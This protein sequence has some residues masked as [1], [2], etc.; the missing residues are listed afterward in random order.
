MESLVDLPV[1][2]RLQDKIQAFIQFNYN[3]SLVF[4]PSAELKFQDI[5]DYL[6]QGTGKPNLALH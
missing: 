5:N 4:A 1:G 3:Q 2:M 6:M